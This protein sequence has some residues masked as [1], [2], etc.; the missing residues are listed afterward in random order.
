MIIRLQGLYM[1]KRSITPDRRQV[2]ALAAPT[3]RTAGIPDSQP[4]ARQ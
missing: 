3:D 1:Q 2:I 4:T